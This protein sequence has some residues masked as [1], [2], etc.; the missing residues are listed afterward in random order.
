MKYPPMPK[1]VM[2][3]N[4]IQIFS[5]CG[6]AVLLSTLN[7]YLQKRG[8]VITHI[9]T[10]VASFFAL[11]FLLHLVGGS[12]G[13]RYFS[14]RGLFG[15]S[16]IMQF[17]GLLMITSS[18][19]NVILA[20]MAFF[21]TGS[22][23]NVSCIN[24]MLMQL[25]KAEDLRRRVAFSVNYSCMNIGFLLSYFVANYFQTQGYYVITFIFASVCLGITMVL[26]VVSWKHIADKDTPFARNFC[27]SPAR[28]ITTPVILIT[29]YLI[30]LFLMHHAQIG[31]ALIYVFFFV[32]LGFMI[33]LALRQAMA[34]R[35]KMIACLIISSAC[36]IY[37]FVQG[38]MST[39]LQN[40][41]HYN[42]N[43]RL[44]GIHFATSGFMMFE[45]AGVI[46]FGFLLA[47]SMRKKQLQGSAM[48]VPNLVTKGIGLNI[49]GFLMV[50]LGVV[51]A[52]FD[53]GHAVALMFPVILLLFVAAAEIRVNAVNYALPGE[54]ILTRY[55]GIFTGYLFLSIAFG[56]NLAG[57]FSNLI[58][59]RYK[60][61]AHVKP[62]Q[63]NPM[64]LKTF[65][66]VSGIVAV[67]TLVY[68]C[69]RGRLQ[70]LMD[71]QPA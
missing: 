30:A 63:T 15:I 36:M 32:V 58:V 60:H 46:I 9:N 11:N 38:L 6:F 1:G 65:L 57:F 10:L 41:V 18:N 31:S 21:L 56:V 2:N 4:L 54:L 39:A 28:Y 23:L 34:E 55:Q 71:T 13:G 70:R 59:G 62:A 17:V 66:V 16:V 37:A 33:R 53:G 14:Y 12:L 50:P 7:L 20:G 42:T 64:Y 43:Q 67:I 22:G 8:M 45:S 25:F 24:L 48:S 40:F 27:Y 44:F 47:R 52:R 29:V 49:I 3:I 69:L 19:L 68:F 26:L 35:R 61:L 5:T 51:V